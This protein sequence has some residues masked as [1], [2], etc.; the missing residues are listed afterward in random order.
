MLSQTYSEY[1]L[2][3][4]DDGSTDGS[5]EI[6]DE[7]RLKDRRIKVIHQ[8]NG[9]LA[10]ARNQGISKSSG[11]YLTFVDSDDWV[12][13]RLLEML[14]EGIGKGATISACGFYTVR[15]DAAKAW[16]NPETGY[17]VVPAV[18]ATK[19]M[20]YTKSIDTSAWAKLYHRSCF[21]HIRFP[22]G[23][24]YE[25]VATTY[26]LFLTQERIAITTTPLYYYVKRPGSIVTSSF[27]E[28][29]MDMLKH[30]GEMLELAEESYPEL[31]PAAR[32]RIVYAC[33]Y[34]LKT[35]GKEYRAYPEQ[36]ERI[37]T[38][39]RAYEKDVFRDPETPGRDKAAILTLRKGPAFFESCW[40]IYSHLTGRNGNQ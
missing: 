16:R 13:A 21:D 5:G 34:L 12:D 8:P 19:D 6:C 20:M 14:W 25:E 32:R 2:L 1:E 15:N 18:E 24:L 29:H 33:F 26:R 4:V 36:V 7:Y 10:N 38:Q 27:S 35:M 40:G 11:E 9:G 22:E 28:K 39:F 17:R 23:R 31:I 3:L 30:S 37:M